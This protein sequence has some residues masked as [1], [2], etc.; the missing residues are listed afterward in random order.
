MRTDELVGS[1]A[2]K[3]KWIRPVCTVCKET[4]KDDSSTEELATISADLL[5][6]RPTNTGYI[7]AS[8]IAREAEE[9]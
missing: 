5:G 1:F 6:W 9:E 3:G 4:A 2:T 8:C 7:C